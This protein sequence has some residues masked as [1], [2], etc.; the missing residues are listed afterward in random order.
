MT[1]TTDLR[2][3]ISLARRMSAS[4]FR[5]YARVETPDHIS[6]RAVRALCWAEALLNR[7]RPLNPRNR[8]VIALSW[9]ADRKADRAYQVVLPFGRECDPEKYSRPEGPGRWP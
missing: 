2:P 8:H 4:T 1:T 3:L 9:A 5:A 6:D 7:L